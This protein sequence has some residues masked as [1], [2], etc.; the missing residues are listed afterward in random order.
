MAK[1]F[2]DYVSEANAVVE[3]VDVAGA[4]ALVGND[5]VQFIDVR[6]GTEVANTGVIPG[7]VHASRGMLEFKIDST[8]PMHD[9][10]FASGKQFVFYCQ[11]GGRSALAAK[12]AMDMGLQRV[13]H[14][15]GGMKAWSEAGQDVD[16]S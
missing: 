14:M 9:A 13:S 16:K 4:A 15:A 1:G 12:L 3:A 10:A 11:T 6:D 2:K 5:D 7:A 8:S